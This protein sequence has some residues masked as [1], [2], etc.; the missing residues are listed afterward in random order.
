MIL[1]Q[2]EYFDGLS[3]RL[4]PVTISLLE[5]IIQLQSD[6]DTITFDLS[7]LKIDPSVGNA[8]SIIYLPNGGEIH[9]TDHQLLKLI[10]QSLRHKSPEYFARHLENKLLYAT[11]ALVITIAIVASG[12]VWGVPFIAKVSA[13]ALSVSTERSL[14]EDTLSTM[15]KIYLSPT[16]LS[17]NRTQ[18]ITNQLEHFCTAT[19]CPSYR[20]LFRNSETIGANAFALPGNTIVITDQLIQKA[21]HDNEIIAVLAHEL[22][23]VRGRHTLRMVLQGM[24]SGVL[25]VM[26]TGDISNFSDLAAG[27]PALLLQQGY[28][29]DMEKEADAFALTSLHKAHIPPHYFADILNRIDKDANE[30]LSI[31]SSHPDT[32]TRIKP[33]IKEDD[34]QH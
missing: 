34:S 4:Q 10:E 24:G 14:G 5:G 12:L 30:S 2:G 15:E 33:F 7:T 8:R 3:S 32:L 28:S 29:R 26:I 1:Y 22:G 21:H 18:E 27:I 6:T 13:M 31:F 9:T 19:E 23:H 20:L 16:L 11:S 25:L 17:S